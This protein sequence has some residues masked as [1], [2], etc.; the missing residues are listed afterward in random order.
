MIFSCLVVAEELEA[1][2]S[3]Y[4]LSFDDKQLYTF[5]SELKEGEQWC[6]P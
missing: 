4:P 5:Q 1:I 6:L 2:G 3:R